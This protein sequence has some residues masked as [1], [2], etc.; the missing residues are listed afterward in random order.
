[1]PTT[2]VVRPPLGSTNTFSAPCIWYISQ[3]GITTDP[4]LISPINGN[5]DTSTFGSASSPWCRAMSVMGAVNVCP[6]CR[7]QSSAKGPFHQ[8]RQD[9]TFATKSPR[10][11]PLT[12]QSFVISSTSKRIAYDVLSSS[13][14]GAQWKDVVTVNI[15]AMG[16]PA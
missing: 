8:T 4:I 16:C 1:M 11:R 12:S 10:F 5:A 2:N 3:L 6:S 14:L 13:S 7:C 9:D 15:A